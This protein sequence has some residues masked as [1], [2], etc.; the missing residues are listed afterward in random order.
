MKKVGVFFMALAFLLL[1]GIQTFIDF[2]KVYS[3]GFSLGVTL[4]EIAFIIVMGIW[5]FQTTKNIK[6]GVE[7]EKKTTK[8][9]G[10]FLIYVGPTIFIINGLL[11][12]DIFPAIIISVLFIGLG[13]FIIS[14]AKKI[15]TSSYK[16]FKIKHKSF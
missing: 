2:I 1:F 16:S 14:A 10:R 9:L 8:F 15:T 4:L 7:K 13:L 5:G 12:R 11:L 6:E 3:I